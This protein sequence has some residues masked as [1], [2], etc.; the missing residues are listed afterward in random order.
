[1][2]LLKF[3]EGKESSYSSSFHSGG[4]Y[5][6][7]DTGVILFKGVKYGSKPNLSNYA[8]KS[9]IS[10]LQ[11]ELENKSDSNHEHVIDDISDLIIANRDNDG[12]MPSSM[13]NKLNELEMID[14]FDLGYIPSDD[15]VNIYGYLSS[16][17]SGN[18]PNCQPSFRLSAAT[19]ASAGVMSSYDKKKLDG[20]YNITDINS[21]GSASA[22]SNSVDVTFSLSR[23]SGPNFTST[24]VISAAT[25]SK[26][27]V[28]SAT[29]KGNLD[30]SINKILVGQ[31]IT[32]NTHSIT[33]YCY[34]NSGETVEKAFTIGS[35]T[36]AQAGL[37]SANDKEK[38]DSLANTLQ[39]LSVQPLNDSSE[40]SPANLIGSDKYGILKGITDKHIG[41]NAQFTDGK[42]TIGLYDFNKSEWVGAPSVTIPLQ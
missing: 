33:L 30:K 37:M 27:G 18:L 36:Q 4:L 6:A 31:R 10:R 8:T 38:L 2:A 23:D 41:V 35:A 16:K 29:D 12:L 1:M 25:T 42:L 17:E 13:Y 15:Y 7:K 9:D 19:S 3:F 21:G 26:A 39:A 24:C 34:T 22:D 5:F 40:I 11:S 20:L 28:M 14:S 32:G